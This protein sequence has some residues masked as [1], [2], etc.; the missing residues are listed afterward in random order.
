M[1][2]F[3]PIFI[4]RLDDANFPCQAK[5]TSKSLSNTSFRPKLLKVALQKP[6]GQQ[7]VGLIPPPDSSSSIDSQCCS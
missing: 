2:V 1:H 4:G 5:Y 6:A 3:H 7:R